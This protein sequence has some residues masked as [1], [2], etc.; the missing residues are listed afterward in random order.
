MCGT[1]LKALN[2]ELGSWGL[3]GGSRSTQGGSLKGM[4]TSVSSLFSLLPALL[5]C[6]KLPEAEVA[7]QLGWG[8]AKW[9]EP[10]SQGPSQHPAQ[11][12]FYSHYRPT[13][14][15]ALVD[16]SDATQGINNCF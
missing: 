13:D 15:S 11:S 14:E 7:Q 10:S 5:G 8:W 16:S 9:K 2:E 6:E 3:A 1:I 4:P 12:L